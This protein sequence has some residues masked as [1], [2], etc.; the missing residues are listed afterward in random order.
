MKQINDN[1]SRIY[2]KQLQTETLQWM[3]NF[4]SYLSLACTFTIHQPD[5]INEQSVDTVWKQW[6]YYSKYLNRQLYGHAA[7]KYGKGLLI[8]P[9]LHG[10]LSRTNLHFHAAI[11]CIDR[12]IKDYELRALVNRCW[13]NMEWSTNSTKIEKYENTNW[14]SYMLK[15]S[16]RLDLQSINLT[17][18]SIPKALLN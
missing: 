8:L 18:A 15:E 7:K 1:N 16:V 3:S 4:D 9:V 2:S 6:E 12:D 10:E 11:G 5:T 17:K 14:I 13:R